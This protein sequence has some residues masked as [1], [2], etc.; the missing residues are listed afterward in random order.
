MAMPLCKTSQ[1]V[2]AAAAQA[3]RRISEQFEEEFVKYNRWC[4]LNERQNFAL[5]KQQ[6][7]MHREMIDVREK[8]TELTHMVNEQKNELIQLMT[9]MKKQKAPAN[10]SGATARSSAIAPVAKT[11]A[12]SAKAMAMSGAAK[13]K[14]DKVN[15]KKA[16][17]KSLQKPQCAVMI[18]EKKET[19]KAEK[20]TKTKISKEGVLNNVG[21]L[22]SFQCKAPQ[23]SFGP[24]VIP[25]EADLT[26]SPPRDG[27]FTNFF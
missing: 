22:G 3:A 13:V 18:K 4:V 15:A 7:E 27:D 11:K 9:M 19:Q 2:E 21:N 23:R 1:V 17:M 10:R 20:I 12:A 16:Q 24:L 26:P 5:H 14:K 8:V 25:G 6:F